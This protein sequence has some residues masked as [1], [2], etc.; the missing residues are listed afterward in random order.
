MI[1]LHLRPQLPGSPRNRFVKRDPMKLPEETLHGHPL[2]ASQR[3]DH[4]NR[5]DLAA[6]RHVLEPSDIV[7]GGREPTKNVNDHGGV[8]DRAHERR[9]SMGLVRDGRS[10]AAML[11]LLAC[12]AEG[13]SRS[14]FVSQERPPQAEP[15]TGGR[16]AAE[17]P[18]SGPQHRAP[19]L[20][21]HRPRERRLP[22]AER[23]LRCPAQRCAAMM[24]DGTLPASSRCGG[25]LRFRAA[26]RST[27]ARS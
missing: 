20:R 26:V 18:R 12:C 6:C 5:G 21:S 24:D 4:L 15:E 19:R 10:G 11:L 8:N 23:P 13:T 2:S 17:R 14:E 7:N 1:F 25:T 3:G 22:D 9:R 27:T 16:Q